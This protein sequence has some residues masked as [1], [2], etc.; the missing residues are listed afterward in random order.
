MF[1]DIDAKSLLYLSPQ[2]PAPVEP[3]RLVSGNVINRDAYIKELYKQLEEHNVHSRVG[4]LV[5]QAQTGFLTPAQKTEFNKLDDTITKAMLHAEKTL[6]TKRRTDWTVTLSKIVHGIRYYKLLLRYTRG[7]RVS[8][9]VIK[10]VASKAGITHAPLDPEGIRPLLKQEWKK[11]TEYMEEAERRRDKSLED[12]IKSG[13][14][15]T[16][17]KRLAALQ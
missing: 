3:R 5:T 13:D 9:Q 15:D 2:E 1:A 17:T 6:P 12:F 11:L 10:K 14:K 8:L 7:E 16:E 4:T